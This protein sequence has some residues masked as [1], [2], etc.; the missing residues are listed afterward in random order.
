M[1]VIS[2]AMPTTMAHVRIVAWKYSQILKAIVCS[3]FSD[4]WRLMK[5]FTSSIHDNI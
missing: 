4:L 5:A 1:T 3:P 2:A